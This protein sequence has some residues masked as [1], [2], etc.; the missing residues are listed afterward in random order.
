MNIRHNVIPRFHGSDTLTHKT[1]LFWGVV[2]LYLSL[3]NGCASVRVTDPA[4]TATEQFLLSEAA[5][6]AVEPLSFQS[7]RGRKVFVD[8]T[9]F[10][11]AEKE[12][13]LAEL[14]AKLLTSGVQLVS[15]PNQAVIV[16]EVRSGGVGIDRYEN[17]LGIPAIAAGPA[18]PVGSSASSATVLTPEI[19]ISKAIKQFSFASVS[20]V[21]YRVDSGEVVT[22]V[23]PSIGRAYRDDYWFLGMG[24]RTLG[25]IPPVD[26]QPLD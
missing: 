18:G 5:R 2:S 25:T 10:A 26:H 16:M 22:S 7:L 11:P 23:G 13:V 15:D 20:Y 24:P 14:R 17:L 21:A 12:F 4:R 9:Y 6:A 1:V 19:A 3:A 8:S